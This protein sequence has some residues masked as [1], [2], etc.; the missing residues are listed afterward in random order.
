MLGGLLA[1]VTVSG[2]LLLYFSPMQVV[3]GTTPRKWLR[4]AMKLM[5]S[6]MERIRP[7]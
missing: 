2:V 3:P 4:K 1:G 5:V 6:G 7:T